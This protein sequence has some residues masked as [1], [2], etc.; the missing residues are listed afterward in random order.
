MII[1]YWAGAK[2]V[3]H[4]TAPVNMLY[5][6][7]QALHLVNE[8]GLENVYARHMANHK[9]L[10]KGLAELGLEMLVDEEY[11][12]PQLN[13]VLVPGGV[14][15]AAVRTRLLKEFGI[16]IGA[17]LGDLAGKIWR[18]GLMGYTSSPESVSRVLSALKT[19]LGK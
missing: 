3:Y 11:R 15:E 17:G 4:H 19:C 2:R 18:I 16:E 6:M 8:E 10:V 13:S 9:L 5:A 12:L 1:N 7:Y 14:D